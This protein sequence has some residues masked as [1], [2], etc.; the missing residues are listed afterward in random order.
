MNPKIAFAGMTHLGLVSAVAAAAK[1]FDVVGY[2]PDASLVSALA[3]RNLLVSEPDLDATLADN[4][5]RISFTSDVEALCNCDLAIL[6]ADVPTG[7][8]GTSDLSPIS[9][10]IQNVLSYLRDDAVFVVLCQVPPGFTRTIA[11]DESRLF[12]QVETLIFGRAMERALHPERFIVGRA[13]RSI[14]LP[15]AYEDYLRAFGC[16]ILPMAYESA[17][18]AKIAINCF[19]VAQVT[20][21]NT[22]AG[23]AEMIGADWQEIAPSLKLDARI[24]PKAYLSPGLGIAGGNLERDLATVRALAARHGSESGLID[25]MLCNSRHRKDWAL[26]TLHREVLSVH[27][28]PV[29]AVLG[30]AYKENTRSTKNSPS[31]ALIDSL[32]PWRVRVYDPVVDADV[33]SHPRLFAAA[34]AM[35]AAADA[36]VLVIATAWPEFREIDPHELRAR[37]RGSAI[38]DPW[39]MLEAAPGFDHYV[40]GA[41]VRRREPTC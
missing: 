8:D 24:G 41:P 14:P 33:V 36:D 37:M 38:I 21:T 39:R 26:T 27:S 30:L 15:D 18:L 5:L 28:D 13:N 3:N 34:S 4:A 40:L 29:I 16:P 1:G 20:T 17:E 25:A 22:L 23:L 10:L 35:E 7:A 11:R 31:L 9:S 19:L 6:S 2:D 12:Y 32:R